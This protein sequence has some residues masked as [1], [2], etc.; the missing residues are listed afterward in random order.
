MV[1]NVAVGQAAS[2]YVA[3]LANSHSTNCCHPGIE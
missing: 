3:L 2:E 1:D